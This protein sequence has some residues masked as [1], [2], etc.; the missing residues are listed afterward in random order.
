MSPACVAESYGIAHAE[1]LATLDLPADTSPITP[2]KQLE[3]DTFW[4]DGLRT[5]LKERVT[6]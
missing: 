5:W 6:P 3:S 4:L 1:L 2:I